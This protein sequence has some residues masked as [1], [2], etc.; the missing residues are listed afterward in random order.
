LGAS[1]LI[2]RYAGLGR[3]RRRRLAFL[4]PREQKRGG[5]ETPPRCV[6]PPVEE[7]EG[8][9]PDYRYELRNGGEVIATGHLT[10][11]QSLEVGDRLS[12]GGHTGPFA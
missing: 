3:G 2:E 7:D 12:I 5:E 1:A 8:A 6:T 11:E 4:P 9:M 10:R